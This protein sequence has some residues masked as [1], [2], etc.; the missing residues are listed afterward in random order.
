MYSYFPWRQNKFQHFFV[1]IRSV[2]SP[3][4][5]TQNNWLE[6]LIQTGLCILVLNSVQLIRRINVPFKSSGD[7]L[8]QA[9]YQQNQWLE[10]ETEK[11]KNQWLFVIPEYVLKQTRLTG[12]FALESSHLEE[13]AWLKQIWLLIMW[14]PCTLA[15]SNT[16]FPQLKLKGPGFSA[17]AVATADSH[18]PYVSN[19]PPRDRWTSMWWGLKAPRLN[20]K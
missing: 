2:C 17:A 18:G 9:Q 8:I 19:S 4:P 12:S 10:R 11:K 1:Y 20:F 6:V 5:Q 3:S 7:H 13:Q 14:Y 15:Y 16:Q